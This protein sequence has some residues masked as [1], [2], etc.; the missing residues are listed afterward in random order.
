[1][2]DL[3]LH[4]L[5]IVQNAITAGA[6]LIRIGIVE[7]SA[8]DFCSISVSDNG[9]GMT[10]EQ[11]NKVKDPYFTSR[12]TRKVGM[13]IPLLEQTS[14]QANGILKIVSAPGVGTTIE[15]T[16][17]HNH[18][19]RP[20]WGDLAGVVSLLAGS[21]PELDFI[22]R[23]EKEGK[24]FLFDTKEIK[25]VLEGMPLS[26]LPVIKYMKQMIAEGLSELGEPSNE[27]EEIER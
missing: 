20:A 2:K 7:D 25:E 9:K 3:S 22:F 6:S 10:A 5:D 27:N 4:I 15:A 13:G 14:R 16:M 11:V 26:E 1:M 17:V 24:E 8:N 12:T 23:Y 19:D 21:N 18:I